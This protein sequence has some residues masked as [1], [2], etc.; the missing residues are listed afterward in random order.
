LTDAEMQWVDV[1]IDLL[2]SKLSIE[3]QLTRTI[4]NIA[5]ALLTPHMTSHSL[6]L[7]TDVRLHAKTDYLVTH[8]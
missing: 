5:V 1:V 3:Q 8:K 2:M 6:Q 7:I 4:V